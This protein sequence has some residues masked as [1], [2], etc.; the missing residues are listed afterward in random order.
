M[1]AHF[2][3]KEP[4]YNSHCVNWG[5]TATTVGIEKVHPSSSVLGSSPKGSSHNL[6]PSQVTCLTSVSYSH[7]I[8]IGIVGSMSL[9]TYVGIA[10]SMILMTYFD[11]GID[12]S[13]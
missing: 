12:D 11:C 4:S 1:Y 6:I 3:A 5:V 7:G 13:R 8:S 10:G 2:G 9:A